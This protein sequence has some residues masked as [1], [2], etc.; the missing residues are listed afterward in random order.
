MVFGLGAIPKPGVPEI[1]VRY[2]RTRKAFLGKVTSAK[3]AAEFLRKVYTRGSIE[4]Q[5][6]FIVLYC[7]QMNEIIGYYKH[8]TGAINAT[9][10]D[11]RIILGTAL[12]S[13][14]TS[15]IIAHNHPSGNLK[16]SNADLQ[17]TKKV[18]DAAKLL[19]IALLDHVII[20]K[21]SYLSFADEGIL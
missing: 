3:D 20:T 6:S 10:A 15:I 11:V 9:I 7:N 2:N 8:T 21:K 16:P 19:D 1:K 5:E 13:A 4:L 14:S 12:S 18:K 17:L